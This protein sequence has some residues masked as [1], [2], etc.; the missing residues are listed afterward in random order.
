[1]FANSTSRLMSL[2]SMLAAA[3]IAVSLAVAMPASQARADVDVDVGI[4]IGVGGG[5]YG[6]GYHGGGYYGGGYDGY[7]GGGY[8]GYHPRPH[9][10][11]NCRQG[12]RIL[13]RSGYSRIE[14]LSCR[15]G[16][17]RYTAWRNG[18][19]FLMAV[20]RSGDVSRLRRIH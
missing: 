15:G 4:G 3:A 20:D 8:G 2:K 12:Q 7:Y 16:V 18:R 10:Y 6:G 19:Q 1:M 17:F 11:V 13:W 9:G 14:V 5:Y